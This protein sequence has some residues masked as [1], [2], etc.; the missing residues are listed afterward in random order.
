MKKKILILG[1]SGQIGTALRQYLMNKYNILNFDIENS[2]SE[3]LRIKN[4]KIDK[5]IKE[6][7]I[8]FFCI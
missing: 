4:Q 7:S 3:D 5:M 6:S 1:S 8:F 2:L